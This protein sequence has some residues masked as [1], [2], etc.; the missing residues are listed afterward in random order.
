MATP[1]WS[2]WTNARPVYTDDDDD[3]GRATQRLYAAELPSGP[4]AVVGKANMRGVSTPLSISAIGPAR[5]LLRIGGER[6]AWFETLAPPARSPGADKNGSPCSD[7][8]A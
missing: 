2:T 8:F 4:L 6:R 7:A 5:K 3:D 1:S